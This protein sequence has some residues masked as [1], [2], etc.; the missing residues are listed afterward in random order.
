LRGDRVV[1]AT[2]EMA[3]TLD[4][5]SNSAVVVGIKVI[6]DLGRYRNMV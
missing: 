4:F 3:A 2:G 6:A 5:V 1:D